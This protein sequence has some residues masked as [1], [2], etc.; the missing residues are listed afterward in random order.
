MKKILGYQ[1]ES[2]DG[3]HEIP[4]CFYSFEVLTTI[5]LAEKW[6]ELEIQN[7]EFGP[8]RWAIFPVFED[9][10]EEPSFIDCI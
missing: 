2:N 4:D 6:M 5:E 9:T 7:P 3:K 8:F 10:I 1:I